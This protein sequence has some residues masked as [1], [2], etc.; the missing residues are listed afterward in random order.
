MV[1]LSEDDEIVPS[2]S[3][4]AAIARHTAAV[5]AGG[6]DDPA[7]VE[8]FVMEGAGHGAIL[9]EE[10]RLRALVD[11]FRSFYAQVCT[12]VRVCVRSCVCARA[13]ACLCV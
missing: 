1:A 3:V 13:R 5:A 2:R 7:A 9:F 10:D 12:C 8:A 4:A 11:R 6:G